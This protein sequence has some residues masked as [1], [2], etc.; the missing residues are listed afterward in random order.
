VR[1]VFL[2]KG[3]KRM[4][5]L[6]KF[7]KSLRSSQTDAESYLWYQLKN[8]NLNGY[9]FRRQHIIQGYIV[10]FVCLE[11]R[12]IIELDGGQHSEQINYDNDRTKK[13]EKDGFK[14]LRFWN[15]DIFCDT[16]VVLDTIYENLKHPSPAASRRPL[17][18]GER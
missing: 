13:L 2:K 9:K 12:L 3:L 14:V 17:P 15:H 8:R 10:D 7:Q 16:N 1:G 4:S 11:E 18:Q 6:K 5:R